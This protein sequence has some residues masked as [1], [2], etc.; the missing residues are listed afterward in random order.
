MLAPNNFVFSFKMQINIEYAIILVS[1]SD[2]LGERLL[3][4]SWG[5]KIVFERLQ[6]L[7]MK[8]R[9][10]VWKVSHQFHYISQSV[11]WPWVWRCVGLCTMYGFAVWALEQ[12][13][14][15]FLSLV[16]NR[17]QESQVWDPSSTKR[18]VHAGLRCSIPIEPHF[19]LLM[20]RN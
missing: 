1:S 4:G 17:H 6:A 9:K 13:W 5:W 16:G 15:P 19:S 18:Q 10:D 11:S 20:S 12:S 2:G 8:G 7:S 3:Q 14:N